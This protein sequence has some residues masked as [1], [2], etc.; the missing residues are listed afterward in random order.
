MDK[1]GDKKSEK[2]ADLDD[3]LPSEDEPLTRGPAN[4]RHKPSKVKSTN[5]APAFEAAAGAGSAADRSDEMSA[6]DREVMTR[7]ESLVSEFKEMKPNS[8]DDNSFNQWAKD[9]LGRFMLGSCEISCG[10]DNAEPN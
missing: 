1:D 8:T 2:A 3:G 5:L 4:K 10:F 9:G 6:E 7:F